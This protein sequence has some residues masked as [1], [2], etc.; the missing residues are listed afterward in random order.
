[1]FVVSAVT[2]IIQIQGVSEFATLPRI[3]EVFEYA[4]IPT[5]GGQILTFVL[6]STLVRRTS[7]C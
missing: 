2:A 4:K 3:A 6:L 1:M 7:G 5:F